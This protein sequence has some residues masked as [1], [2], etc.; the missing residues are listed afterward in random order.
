MRIVKH[1]FWAQYTAKDFAELPRGELIAVLPVGAVEQHG[2]HLPLAVDQ[3][4]VDGMVAAVVP[5]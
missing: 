5:L 3:A 2:P 1:R 4:I